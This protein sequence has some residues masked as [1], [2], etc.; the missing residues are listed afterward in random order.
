MLNLLE[1]Y[2]APLRRE[3]R[4]T[5]WS[6][7]NLNAG[8]QWE[9]KLHKHLESAD[10]ILLLISPDF[11]ASDYCYSYEMTR[12]IE[13]HDDGSAVVIPIL[14]R[15]TL[16]HKAPFAKLQMIPK[17]AKPVSRW[18]DS[19]EAFNDIVMQVDQVVSE[20]LKLNR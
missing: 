3:D 13:R 7:T 12:A 2:L 8:V 14:L 18:P 9:E 11:M 6:D 10:I 17:N 20:R 19:D 15:P 4:F 5:I 1:I 16:W